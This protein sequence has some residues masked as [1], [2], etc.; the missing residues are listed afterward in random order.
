MT[1]TVVYDNQPCREGLETGWGFSALVTGMEKTILFDTGRDDSLLNNMKTLAIKPESI[2]LVFLSHIHPDHTG[3]LLGFLQENSDVTIYLPQSFPNEFKIEL[4][5]RGARIVEVGQPLAICEGV[6]STGQVGRWL[7]EQSLI[8]RTEK[9]IVLITGCSHPGI[10]TMVKATRKLFG[11]DILLVVGGF[12]LEWASS[13]KTE[14]I[15]AAF[16]E[17]GVRYVAPAHCAGERAKAL[18]QRQFQQN[19][20]NIGA[21]ATI[22]LHELL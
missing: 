6:Y 4:T 20:I 2:D 22:N 13:R 18:F 9:G 19:Y 8:L 5:A 7:R 16:K 1:I 3:G 17:L 14:R 10:V 15:V 12:H 21:A 11:D